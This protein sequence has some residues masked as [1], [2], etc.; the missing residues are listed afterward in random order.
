MVTTGG[1]PVLIE[2]IA[3]VWG[4]TLRWRRLV[5]KVRS[6]LDEV[7]ERSSGRCRHALLH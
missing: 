2:A 7:R 6:I 1:A 3:E 5:H 4:K